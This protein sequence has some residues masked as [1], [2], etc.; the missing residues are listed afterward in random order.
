MTFEISSELAEICGI[1]AGDGYLRGADHRKELDISG[2]IE[3]KSYYD[4]HVSELFKKVFNLDIQ[5]KFFQSRNTY[6]FVIRDKSTIEFMHSLGFPYGNKSTTIKVPDF[7]I[8]SNNKELIIKFL[9]GLFDTDGCIHFWKRNK[10]MYKSFKKKYHYYPIIK[11]TGVSKNLAEDVKKILER[12]EFEKVGYYTY[13]PK[14]ETENIKHTI[15]LYGPDK[16]NKF[17]KLIGSKNPVKLSRF[18]IWKNIGHCP[19]H[20]TL[21]QRLEM[22]KNPVKV[23]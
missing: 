6:G 18:L 4:E 20:S 1:H 22:L 17:L 7:I 19:S 11:F 5:C 16:T 8:N 12:L 13:K 15:T 23:A 3:E 10:G 14:K 2:N 21:S 9:R